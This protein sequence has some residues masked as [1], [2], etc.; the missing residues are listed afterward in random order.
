MLSRVFGFGRRSFDSLSE[1]EILAQ[2]VLHCLRGAVDRPMPWFSA[3]VKAEGPDDPSALVLHGL[4][5]VVH[6]LHEQPASPPPGGYTTIRRTG[7]PGNSLP[8]AAYTGT[9]RVAHAASGRH[10]ATPTAAPSAARQA[11]KAK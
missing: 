9:A 11:W 4:D 8:C 1:Q 6:R 10:S 3:P 7:F 2:A 5:A